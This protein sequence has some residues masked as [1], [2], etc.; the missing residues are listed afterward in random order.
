MRIAKVDLKKIKPNPAN[1]RIIKNFKFDYLVKSII[2]FP[3]MLDVRPMVVDEGFIVQGGNMRLKALKF[4][5]KMTDEQHAV[6]IEKRNEYKRAAL[7]A[8]FKTFQAEKT[9]DVESAVDWTEE[10]KREFVV[11]DNSNFGEF[12]MD[13]LAN[14][15]SDCPLVEWG[16]DVLQWEEPTERGK[17]ESEIYTLKFTFEKDE[18][19]HVMTLLHQNLTENG[20]QSDD[21]WRE[22]CLLRLLK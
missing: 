6:Q 22:R 20:E 13:S 10:Q 7:T 1:P 2:N 15:F 11:K 16:V 9:I 19:S 18:A 8:W 12:D 4:I 14:Q 21:K 3:E 5:L 17:E